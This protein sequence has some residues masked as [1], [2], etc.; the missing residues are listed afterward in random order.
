MLG[1]PMD[2]QMVTREATRMGQCFPAV[3][4]KSLSLYQYCR[5]PCQPLLSLGPTGVWFAGVSLS[6]ERAAADFDVEF[7]DRFAYFRME[8]SCNDSPSW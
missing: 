1:Y 6:P 7:A 2:L 5:Y 3:E 8:E 4:R